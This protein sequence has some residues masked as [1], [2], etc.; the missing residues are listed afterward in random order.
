MAVAF[1]KIGN[2]PCTQ[3]SSQC[4]SAESAAISIVKLVLQKFAQS[5]ESPH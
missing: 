5:K 4:G 3:L 2:A 1:C